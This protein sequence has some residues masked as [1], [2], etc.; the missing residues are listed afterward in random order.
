MES[1]KHVLRCCPKIR[2]VWKR[3]LRLMVLIHVNCVITWDV[4]EWGILEGRLLLYENVEIVETFHIVPPLVQMVQPF[5]FDRLQIRDDT[6][7]KTIS[8]IWNMF[9]SG[10]KYYG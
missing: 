4:V 1:I 6:I 10:N 2:Q 5:L 8:S 3:V 7:W 9:H